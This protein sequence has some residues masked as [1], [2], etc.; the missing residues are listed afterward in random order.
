MIRAIE[1]ASKANK[2]VETFPGLDYLLERLKRAAASKGTGY[3]R[4]KQRSRQTRSSD[5]PR[6][7]G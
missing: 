2:P 5:N 1:K 4:G 7:D 3:R 6:N